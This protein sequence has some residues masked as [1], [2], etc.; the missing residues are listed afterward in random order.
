M[1]NLPGTGDKFNEAKGDCGNLSQSILIEWSDDFN[2]KNTLNL[3]FN[4][5]STT[6]EFSLKEGIFNLST[7]VVPGSQNRTILYYVGTTF[8]APKDKSYHC[9]R[10]QTL[11]LTDTEQVS[12]TTIPVGTVSVS[13]VLV[14]AFHSGDKQ[15][16]STAID[17]DAINTP[18]NFRN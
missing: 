13:S 2:E 1:F 14:E 4:L 11:N 12:N 5:N 6:K 10:V 16:F 18:G 7:K 9:T 3:T 17:C 8:E 15:E